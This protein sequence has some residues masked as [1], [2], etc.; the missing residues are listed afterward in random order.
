MA[1]RA[2]CASAAVLGLQIILPRVF[3]VLL[4]YH[5]GFL[6]VSLAM[7][8]FAAGGRLVRW[9]VARTGRP[10]G[11]LSLGWLGVGAALTIPGAIVLI[12]RLPV[13][14]S[15]LLEEPAAMLGLGGMVAALA[16][17]FVLLGAQVCSALDAGREQLGRVYGATFLGGA[18][19]A[20]LALAAMEL[21]G[22]PLALAVVSV[23]PLLPRPGWG[24][25]IGVAAAA[26]VLVYPAELLPFT[27]RKHFPAISPEQVLEEREGATSHV[28]FYE[29]LQHHG[30]W[31]NDPDYE[32]Y[33]P[34]SIAAAIDAWAIT[35][36]TKRSGPDDYPPFL[37][38]HP[39]GLSFEGV[40]PGFETLIIG[41]G[42]GWDVLQALSAGAGHVTAVEINPFI[43]DAVEDRWAE[44]SGNLYAD[45]R[46]EVHVA[47]GRHWV[48][49]D[50]RL[51]D[52]I[53]LA[54]VDTFAA[55]QAGAFAL[56]ENYLYTVEAIR[57]YLRLLK[58][59]GRIV[60]T[61]WWF[62][63]PRQTLRLA[64][65]IA[66]ALREE[67]V[68]D[69]R[70]RMYIG[71]GTNAL[72]FLKGG[73]DFDT[74]ELDALNAACRDRGV[75]QAY[76]WASPWDENPRPSHPIL[77][78]A[79]DAKDP[80]AWVDA[81]PYR[82]DPTTDDQ[83]F[84][85]EN[86][87]LDTLFRAEGNWIHDR[88]GG[89]EVLVAT[90]FALLLL[91]W[92]L[93]FLGGG[94]G[95]RAKSEESGSQA[96]L[97][98]FLFL[99]VGFLFVEIPLLQRLSL[100]LGHPVHSVSVVLVSL[101]LWSG[102]GS[103]IAGRMRPRLAPFALMLAAFTIAAVL[104]GARELLIEVARELS[105]PGRIAA[106]V[107][108][109]ALPGITMGM[110]FPLAVRGLG[111][112]RP[113]LVPSAFILNG[114]ASVLAGPLAVLAALH[115]GFRTTLL[116]GAACYVIGALLLLLGRDTDDDEPALARDQPTTPPGAS[117]P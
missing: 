50:E 98:P 91:A 83:P 39:A 4:W 16:V 64:L 19:G 1:L 72:L 81:Y 26:T 60:F 99:G 56:S 25:L 101:L 61:R 77:V 37:E 86:G 35:F 32:G 58:P 30:L 116:A 71:V 14:V 5:L 109:L 46:V 65:T 106:V 102:L 78:Q 38:A 11:G 42:G 36:I 94:G 107:A 34:K 9:R 114:F 24:G 67:G 51:Y 17:P 41:A 21:G 82:V 52:R 69:A 95:S 43:V 73:A 20:A 89:Q 105:L 92:P 103:L 88:L 28:V 49:N 85:F 18:L 47:E 29:N 7:L 63:P 12:L 55:T 100:V 2:G 10:G 87:K 23:L 80:V 57:S 76:A 45:P 113:L 79:L 15:V 110:G 31:A 22:T 62:D 104:V 59:G 66:E 8:G 93:L 115:V 84:F 13:D 108:F 33:I 97:A 90:L 48:D 68:E 117:T 6:A 40:Q 74:H 75:A 96:S 44:Y 53:V 112:E 27:S 54:G 111:L 3:S 70:K